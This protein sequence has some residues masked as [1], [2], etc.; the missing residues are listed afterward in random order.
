MKWNK[1]KAIGLGIV[2][3]V[4][5]TVSAQA[6]YS[7][8]EFKAEPFVRPE[9][10]LIEGERK[11][12][13][14]AGIH[15]LLRFGYLAENKEATALRGRK[16][17]NDKGNIVLEE[18]QDFEGNLEKLVKIDWYSDGLVM[19]RMEATR[20]S[21]TT[22]KDE[23]IIWD[24]DENGRLIEYSFKNGTA[25]D[26][27][28]QYAFND[29]GQM[30][31][32][33]TFVGGDT[34]GPNEKYDYDH[35]GRLETLWKYGFA[36]V[37]E[38]RIAYEY[39]GKNVIREM[40]YRPASTEAGQFFDYF[41]DAAGRLS[42]R[43]MTVAGGV[44]VQEETWTY[45]ERGDT[46]KHTQFV[47]GDP[48]PERNEFKYDAKGR[49]TEF[50]SYDPDG[51]LFTWITYQWDSL[52]KGAGWSRLS[53]S[54]TIEA[55]HLERYDSN[56]RLIEIQDKTAESQQVKRETF[57]FDPKGKPLEHKIYKNGEEWAV[58]WFVIEEE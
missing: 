47:E 25:Q 51:Y 12:M 43:V 8:D 45:N 13:D 46:L 11:A 56:G 21:Q 41:Y 40:R 5:C 38:G 18:M 26:F 22:G 15:I 32:R 6:Q 34:P 29:A 44:K 49:R 55:K 35:L 14:M 33:R 52:G 16:I 39:R 9:R 31:F 48:A 36:D 20:Y 42:K 3:M 58:Y 2:S 17:L 27:S 24:W 50:K 53:S 10:Y 4:A 54:G 28:E 23:T 1:L 37:E 57:T 7:G 19:K 30:L